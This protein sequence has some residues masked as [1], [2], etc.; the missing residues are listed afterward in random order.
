MKIY[1][2]YDHAGKTLEPVVKAIA[3]E[4][5][6]ELEDLGSQG[7]LT[8]DYPDFARVVAEKVAQD[9]LSVGILIC[10]TGAGMAMAANKIHGIRAAVAYNPE[11]ARLIRVDNNANVLALGGR[12]LDVETAKAIIKIFLSTPFEGGRHERR[13]NKI[14]ALEQ[15]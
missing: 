8:D 13:V 5:A 1:L 11:V 9:P 7:D 4:L 12:I 3:S 14:S 2:G 6:F 15:V 10:G